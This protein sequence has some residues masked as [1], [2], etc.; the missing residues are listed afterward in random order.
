MWLLQG[1]DREYWHWTDLNIGT[2]VSVVTFG[3]ITNTTLKISPHQVRVYGREV[4]LTN[5]DAFTRSHLASEGV[6]LAP[7]EPRPQDE[8]QV[9][10]SSIDTP[11]RF[12]YTICTI[13]RR[14]GRGW[15][16]VAS[17]SCTR[18][19][20]RMTASPSSCTT[21]AA[22]SATTLTPRCPSRYTECRFVDI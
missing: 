5:C 16:R 17:C 8:Y 13:C 6:E 7:V 12:I 19:R 15:G 3:D 4:T 10:S 2:K 1:A 20:T 21:T 11:C 22:S 14:S 18:P 9:I